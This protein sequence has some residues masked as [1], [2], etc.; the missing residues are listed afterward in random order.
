MTGNNK[1][2]VILITSIV[3]IFVLLFGIIFYFFFPKHTTYYVGSTTIE[4]NGYWLAC[5][6]N[7]MKAADYEIKNTNMAIKEIFFD[8]L[9]TYIVVN[10]I[11]NSNN[12]LK[13]TLN[14][15]KNNEY[16][17]SHYF[18]ISDNLMV[19]IWD[20]FK[21]SKEVQFCIEL[22][23]IK[24]CSD[25]FSLNSCEIESIEPEEYFEEILLHSI[26][27]GKTSTLINIDLYIA[28]SVEKFQIESK[29][30][31]RTCRSC[32]SSGTSYSILFPIVIDTEE[33]FVIHALDK[34]GFL[35]L[36]IPID[37]EITK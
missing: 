23:N 18:S 11:D 37:L 14:D 1:K 16:I 12:V 30:E 29:N 34:E 20:N 25:Y 3:I 26:K 19:F 4:D 32:E 13:A 17:S 7:L 28:K 10:G 22:L 8:G 21:G 31:V 2:K 35:I 6:L 5:D 33:T 24:G 36:S 15:Q 9:R 27:K